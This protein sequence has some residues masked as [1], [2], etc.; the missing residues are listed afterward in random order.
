MTFKRL[1]CFLLL[2]LLV[3]LW[4]GLLWAKGQIAINVK[5]VLASQ[6]TDYLDPELSSLTKELQSVFRYSSYR[7][8]S[9]HA[10]R[11]AIEDTATVSLPG[12]RILKMTPMG[13]LDD[14]IELK[15]VI[16]KK[17]QQIFETLIKLLNHGSLTVGGP[18]HQDGILLFHISSSF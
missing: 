14:R 17:N 8:L 10:V 7:L 15:L 5:T 18:K 6:E 16:F 1:Q 12:N 2:I 11:L 9:K 3:T 13:I 4:T